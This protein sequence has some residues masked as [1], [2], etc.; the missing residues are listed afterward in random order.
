MMGACTH[1]SFIGIGSNL[2][3]REGN[4]KRAI[5]LLGKCD[6][7]A[8][9]KT[10]HIYETEAMANG[11]PSLHPP[12][13]NTVA[14]ISTPLSP[15]ELLSRLIQIEQM[16]GRPFPREKNEPRAV[17]L[18]ILFFDDIVLDSPALKIPHPEIEKRLFVLTP[19]CDIARAFRHPRLGLT[20]AEIEKDCR[21]NNPA[22][23]D[24]WR[25]NNA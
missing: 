9:K 25:G 24:K 7:I 14:K 17:D 2:G 3:D 22:K 16:F 6:G 20:V 4:I 13:F 8:V 10:S 19:L 12:F 21:I 1:V 11:R 23:I 18:D 5:D 15:E